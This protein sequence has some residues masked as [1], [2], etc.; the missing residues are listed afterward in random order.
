MKKIV[1]TICTVLFTV[2][3]FNVS[4]QSETE[5]KAW[6]EYMTPGDVHKML[7]KSDGE[8]NEEISMWMAPGAPPQKSNATCVNKM[9]LGG[10]YQSSTHTGSFSGM[11]FEGISTVAY[12]NA[13]KKFIT[14]WIDNMGTGIMVMEGSWDE[15]T[16]TLHTKGKQT[17]PMSGKDMD[18]RETFQII[19]DNTQK[20]EMF[21]TNAGAKEF[22][23]ME[24]LL[25]RK[26]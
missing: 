14:T 7:A 12:D 16:K 21:M 5:M 2:I 25:T 4:A 24:I 10:R 11:P 15:K 26:K 8:W 1:L 20:I 9:I 13:K 18:V 17:D 22:K 3:C 6:M 19:D 23:S